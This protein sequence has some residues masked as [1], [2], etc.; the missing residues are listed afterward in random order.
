MERYDHQFYLRSHERTKDSPSKILP[1]LFSLKRINSVVDVGCGIGAWL[2][3]AKA[4][5]ATNVRGIEGPWINKRVARVDTRDLQIHDLEVRL[6]VGRK[7][8]L[9]ISLEVA[10]HLSPPRA[11]SFV[12]DL[13]ELGDMILFSAAI[14]GQGGKH[15]INEQ[16]QS[17][18]AKQFF[19]NNFRAFDFIRPAIWSQADIPV[20]YRQ[21]ILTFA[22]VGSNADAAFSSVTGAIEDHSILDIVHPSLYLTHAGKH[23]KRRRRRLTTKLSSTRAFSWMRQLSR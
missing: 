7:F 22:R 17:F 8:D 3:C 6:A 5:G 18:W 12:D 10:E 20:W 19:D 2:E 14:P 15:H 21:N 9:V 16:W 4:L 1:M 11:R 23:K 13:C